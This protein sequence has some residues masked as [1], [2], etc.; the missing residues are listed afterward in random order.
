MAL[1]LPM[2]WNSWNLIEG[3]VSEQI[4]C[5]IADAIAANGLQQAGC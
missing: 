4:I 3:E 2:G 5:E 1:T